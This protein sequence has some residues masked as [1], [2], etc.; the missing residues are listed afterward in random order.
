MDFS[1]IE[2][3]TSEG[4]SRLCQ[5]IFLPAL[6]KAASDARA[7]DGNPSNALNGVTMAFGEM[8]IALIGRPATVVLLRG[9]ADHLERDP[10]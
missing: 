2:S 1:M 3:G 9:F 6:Q 8:L 10:S 5:Q 4:A 7:A